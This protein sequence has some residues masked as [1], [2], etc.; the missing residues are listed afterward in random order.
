MFWVFLP[1]SKD[2]RSVLLKRHILRLTQ[3]ALISTSTQL[4]TQRIR[5]CSLYMYMYTATNARFL[6]SN[7]WLFTNIINHLDETLLRLKNWLNDCQSYIGVCGHLFKQQPHPALLNIY[8][9]PSYISAIPPTRHL[10][11]IFIVLHNSF[12][13][14][15]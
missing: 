1:Y 6:C 2:S 11:F 8:D 7:L 9:R 3:L 13:L 14:L 12:N 10:Q 5:Y 4:Q 15:L